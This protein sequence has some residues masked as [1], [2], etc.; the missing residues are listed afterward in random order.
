MARACREVSAAGWTAS[1]VLTWIRLRRTPASVR[2]PIALLQ[3]RLR[4]ATD[5]W[6]T[7]ETRQH[8][9]RQAQQGPGRERPEDLGPLDHLQAP[10]P[11]IARQILAALDR[12]TRVRADRE[13]SRGLSAT[14]VDIVELPPVVSEAELAAA[15]REPEWA[16][17]VAAFAALQLPE[18]EYRVD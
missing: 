15:R 1:E 12:G 7:P 6:S 11:H 3:H 10:P 14:E 8:G 5:C 13:R 17:A 2:N 4:G 16:E 18:I 9:V